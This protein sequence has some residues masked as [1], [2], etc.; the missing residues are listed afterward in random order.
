M[1]ERSQAPQNSMRILENEVGTPRRLHDV[2]PGSR[3]D[4]RGGATARTPA[5]CNLLIDTASH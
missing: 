4:S 5:Y 2:P 1:S 3:A